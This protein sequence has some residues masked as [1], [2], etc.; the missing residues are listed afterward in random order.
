[1]ETSAV[2]LAKLGLFAQVATEGKS[3]AE[4]EPP[5]HGRPAAHIV[6]GIRHITYNIQALRTNPAYRLSALILKG[7]EQVAIGPSAYSYS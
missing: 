3:E 1:M 7:D 4:S 2:G 5:D 6:I